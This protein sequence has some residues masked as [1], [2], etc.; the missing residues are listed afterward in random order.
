MTYRDRDLLDLAKGMP[1][2]LR[3]TQKCLGEGGETTVAAHSNMG[4]HGK[5]KSLKADDCYSVWACH[6]CHKWLDQGK[7]PQD[8]KETAWLIAYERQ[9]DQ[10]QEIADNPL[11][12]PWKVDACRRVIKHLE[13]LNG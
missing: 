9:I 11:M 3:V 5:G 6:Y 8:E 12:R 4:I 1:C 10:W 13:S 2:L 7:S